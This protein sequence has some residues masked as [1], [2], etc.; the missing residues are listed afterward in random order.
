MADERVFLVETKDRVMRVTVPVGFKVTFGPLMPFEPQLKYPTTT[1]DERQP[2]TALR[3]YRAKD[4]VVACIPGVVQFREL[5]ALKVEVMQYD[6][7]REKWL[8][9]TRGELE[10][11]TRRRRSVANAMTK[12]DVEG[13]L[14]F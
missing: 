12:G 9:D 5:G 13:S 10:R 14:P 3:V 7:G 2:R 6:S 4:D 8:D 11:S 1:P